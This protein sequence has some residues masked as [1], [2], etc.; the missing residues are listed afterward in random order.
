LDQE[1]NKLAV[2]LGIRWGSRDKQGKGESRRAVEHFCRLVFGN[3][4]TE[5]QLGNLGVEFPV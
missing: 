3:V 5:E 1:I 2:E 4:L